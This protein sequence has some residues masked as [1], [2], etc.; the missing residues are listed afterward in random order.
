MRRFARHALTVWS[1]ASLVYFG[2]SVFAWI[3][4][5]VAPSER[6]LAVGPWES[7]I[8]IEGAVTFVGRDG[9]NALVV[10]VEVHLLLTVLLG[11][12]PLWWGIDAVRR[13]R[14]DVRRR[15]SRRGFSVR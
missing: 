3:V 14:A 11:V 8:M 4:S 10:P 2:L 9:K 15:L 6:R 7:V 5:L 12:L 1:T 13:H